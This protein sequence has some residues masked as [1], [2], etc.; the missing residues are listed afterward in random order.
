MRTTTVAVDDIAPITTGEARV[1]AATEYGRLGEVLRSLGPQEWVLPTD[2]P[3][4][5]VRSMA[6]HCVGMAS[7]F[8]SL[9]RLVRRQTAAVLAARRT[10]RQPVDEMTAQQVGDQATLDTVELIAR[11]EQV[12]PAAARWRAGAPALLRKL[13]I[14]QEVGGVVEKWP[15]RYLLD[16]ILTRDPW[17]HRVDITQVTGHEMVLTRTHDG[18]LVA[19]VVAEWARRHRQPFTLTLT[20]PIGATYVAGD[21][22]GE[23]LTLDTVEF[24][25]TISGRASGSGLL[26]TEVPF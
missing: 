11:L 24:C 14:P 16:V 21:G 10:G 5:D 19:D 17:M 23:P 9:R 20:G 15:M 12:G 8:T 3:D 13:P 7:D 2:C 22:S 6:G 18:R 4:W 26:A 1:L 25:R